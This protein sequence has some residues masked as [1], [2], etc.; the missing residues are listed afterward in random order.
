M[1]PFFGRRH[2]QQHPADR[3]DEHAAQQQP[4]DDRQDHPRQPDEGDVG[5]EVR[6]EAGAHAADLAFFGDADEPTDTAAARRPPR[7]RSGRY[8]EPSSSSLKQ[9][10]QV[11]ALSPYQ[12]HTEDPTRPVS[13]AESL[14]KA[15]EPPLHLVAEPA[16]GGGG[17]V[18]GDA[19]RRNRAADPS[20]AGPRGC[21]RV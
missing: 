8:A 13:A 4:G 15:L 17:G 3:V 9:R 12:I 16:L 10:A 5:I 6:G 20:P 2:R 1:L 11:M 21:L 7:R 19:R 14:E 18:D